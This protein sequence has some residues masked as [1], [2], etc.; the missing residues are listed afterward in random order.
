M[1]TKKKTGIYS[2]V[3]SE[4]I[5]II[6]SGEKKSYRLLLAYLILSRYA[7]KKNVGGYGENRVSG[8]GAKSI[9][10]KLSISWLRAKCLIEALIQLKVIE[11]APPSLKA[12][13]SKAMYILTMPGDIQIPHSLI[14]GLPNVQGITRLL[15][16]EVP[17]SSNVITTAIVILLHFYKN[18]DMLRFGGVSPDI[19]SQ[20]WQIDSAT[21]EGKGFKVTASKVNTNNHGETL[22]LYLNALNMLGIHSSERK[23]WTPHFKEALALLSSSRLTYEAVTVFDAQLV[24]QFPIRINDFHSALKDSEPSF[25]EAIPGAGFY[26]RGEFEKFWM[27]MPTDPTTTKVS[28]MGITRLRFRAAEPTTAI[29]FVRDRSNIESCK[30]ALIMLDIIDDL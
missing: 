27:Y 9:G 14:D 2:P 17:P 12:L 18:H 19:V 22:T 11:P 26:T 6:A 4:A 16:S 25:I 13:N 15:E 29:S 3:S 7:G 24:P 8:A 28:I 23:T 1:A 5:K 20:K 30:S 21:I 10:G